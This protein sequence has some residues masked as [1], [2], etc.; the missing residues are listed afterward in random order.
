MEISPSSKKLLKWT[1]ITETEASQAG[2]SSRYVG[3][4]KLLLKDPKS[5]EFGNI[6]FLKSD[7]GNYGVCG[8]VNAKN[9]FGGYTGRS[10]FVVS[11]KDAYLDSNDELSG[12]LYRAVARNMCAK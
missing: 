3:L 6:R 8:E 10:G 2:I 1:P 9:S 7:R 11:D 4:V 5:A 12:M